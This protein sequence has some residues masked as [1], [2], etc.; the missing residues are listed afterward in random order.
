MLPVVLTVPTAVLLALALQGP[1]LNSGSLETEFEA[2]RRPAGGADFAQGT[3]ALDAWA[4]L[5]DAEARTYSLPGAGFRSFSARVGSPQIAAIADSMSSIPG[6]NLSFAL[7]WQAPDLRRITLSGAQGELSLEIEQRLVGLVE[8]LL[9]LLVPVSPTHRLRSHAFVF[10]ETPASISSR[11]VIEARARTPDDPRRLARFTIGEQGLIVR[12]ET[13][14]DEGDVS[15]YHYAH[16]EREGR[17]LLVGVTG[18]H[19]GTRV[20]LTI[21][22]SREPDQL[23]V[24][25]RVTARQLDALGRPEGPLGEIEYLISDQRIDEP[26][27]SWVGQALNPRR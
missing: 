8:P 7:W 24:P 27:P 5:R 9:E 2:P 13:E 16:V 11:R 19:R 14:T 25:T 26:V 20:D 23:P 1:V 22:W 6:R 15:D 12:Q 3:S 17:F 21:H 4:A 18:T 10:V